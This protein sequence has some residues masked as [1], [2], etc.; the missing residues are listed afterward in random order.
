M[1]REDLYKNIDMQIYAERKFRNKIKQRLSEVSQ[2][3]IFEAKKRTIG[4]KLIRAKIRHVLKTIAEK[5]TTVTYKS[6]GLNTLDDLFMNSNFLSTIETSY[7]TLT[8]SKEQRDDYRDHIISGITDMFKVLDVKPEK[9][10]KD[11]SETLQRLLEEEEPDITIDVEDELQDDEIVGP[12]AREM[13]EEDEGD[14]PE[15][16]ENADSMDPSQDLTGRNRSQVTLAKIEKSVRDYYSE[17]GNPAD[18]NDY[19]M[20]DPTPESNPEVDQAITDAEDTV[21]AVEGGD[22]EMDMEEP[23]EE[24][25]EELE[26]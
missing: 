5:K 1:K 18:K 6:T 15:N 3:R 20:N 10:D 12:E 22:E 7:N 11:L 19:K 23:A 21:D 8:T 17:L 9:E 16:D 26:F 14:D 24:G 4:E 2:N 25:E 13:E